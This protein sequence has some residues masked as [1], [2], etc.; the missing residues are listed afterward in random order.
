M[1]VHQFESLQWQELQCGPIAVPEVHLVVDEQHIGEV[2]QGELASDVVALL[3][4]ENVRLVSGD[5]PVPILKTE[6]HF[7]TGANKKIIITA[8]ARALF[9]PLESVPLNIRRSPVRT[10]G[11]WHRAWGHS[12]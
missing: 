11:T 1:S 5:G 4:G 7:Q 8:N 9:L 3:A 6:Q 10:W 12:V 2:G